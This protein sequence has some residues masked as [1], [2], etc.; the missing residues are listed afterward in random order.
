[1]SETGDWT[2]SADDWVDASARPRRWATSPLTAAMARKGGSS[3]PVLALKFKRS[4][5]ASF[6]RVDVVYTGPDPASASPL[7]GPSHVRQVWPAHRL[8]L[9]PL[10]CREGCHRPSAMAPALPH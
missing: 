4:A 3:D 1:M 5:P 8:R 6:P 10:P 7:H 9:A 2:L